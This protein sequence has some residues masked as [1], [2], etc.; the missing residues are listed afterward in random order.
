VAPCSPTIRMLVL[1]RARRHAEPGSPTCSGHDEWSARSGGHCAGV[2]TAAIAAVSRTP[3]HARMS[4]PT[5]VA[6]SLRFSRMACARRR[7]A[8]AAQDEFCFQVHGLAVST[9]AERRLPPDVRL[10]P[11]YRTSALFRPSPVV[12]LNE[13]EHRPAPPCARALA[14]RSLL[15]PSRA[16]LFPALVSNASAA[17]PLAR[18]RGRPNRRASGPPGPFGVRPLCF[19]GF[20]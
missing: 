2:A 15:V 5:P 18:P 11:A 20:P 17:F 6:E 8:M 16:L 3:R 19:P 13:A 14:P 4:H 10:D 9:A 7:R 1:R 12:R